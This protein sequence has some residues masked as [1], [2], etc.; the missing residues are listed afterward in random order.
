[1]K[2]TNVGDSSSREVIGPNELKERLAAQKAAQK[3]A[4]YKIKKL[5]NKSK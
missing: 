5:F 3:T 2:V 4:W 1:M